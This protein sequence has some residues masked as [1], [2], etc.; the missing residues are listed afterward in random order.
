MVV[1]KEDEGRRGDY[2]SE[3]TEMVSM[4]DWGIVCR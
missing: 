4:G 1:E 3:V 2:G